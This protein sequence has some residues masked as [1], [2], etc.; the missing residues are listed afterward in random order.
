MLSTAGCYQYLYDCELSRYLSNSYQQSQIQA[1]EKK[2]SHL[3]DMYQNGRNTWVSKG[4]ATHNTKDLSLNPSVK[5]IGKHRQ[6]DADEPS[7][8]RESLAKKRSKWDKSWEMTLKA[9]LWLSP[10]C[11]CMFT[12]RNKQTKQKRKM[13]DMLPLFSSNLYFLMKMNTK[14]MTKIR[15]HAGPQTCLS[16]SMATTSVV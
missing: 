1:W 5:A 10:K 2:K 11:T 13:E 4:L 16:E 8:S 3:T 15:N 7:L 9:V 6:V 14:K 12:Q